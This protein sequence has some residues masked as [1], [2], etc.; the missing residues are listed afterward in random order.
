MRIHDHLENECKY[1]MKIWFSYMSD[2]IYYLL[3]KCHYITAKYEY[4][5][6][7]H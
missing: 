5:R 1:K 2:E 4:G 6:T 3:D 7:F